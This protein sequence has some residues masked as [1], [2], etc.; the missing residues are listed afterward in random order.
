MVNWKGVYMVIL[1][2]MSQALKPLLFTSNVFSSRLPILLFKKHLTCLVFQT[3]SFYKWSNLVIH[4]NVYF[5]MQTLCNGMQKSCKV[6]NLLL[7]SFL[8][9]Y[10]MD[11]WI[12]IILNLLPSNYFIQDL[13][14]L[15][16]GL[17][18]NHINNTQRTISMNQKQ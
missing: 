1:F 16:T 6:I 8:L 4:T 3:Q 14:T 15:N 10:S 17:L 18:L 9:E 2:V 12:M 5:E 7:C 11:E 13:I